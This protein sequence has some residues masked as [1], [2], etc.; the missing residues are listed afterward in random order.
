MAKFFKRARSLLKENSESQPLNVEA[1][2][3]QYRSVQSILSADIRVQGNIICKGGILIEGVIDGDVKSRSLRIGE[4][5]SVKGTVEAETIQVRGFL[6]GRIKAKSV[7]LSSSAK[8]DGDISYENLV[9]EEGALLNGTC[10]HM[11][12]D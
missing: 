10:K 2:S 5:G 12:S 3:N 7:T 1:Y 4:G 11:D 8:V 6:T 9:I